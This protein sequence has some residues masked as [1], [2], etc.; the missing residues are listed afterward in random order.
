MASR[1]VGLVKSGRRTEVRS[2]ERKI[3]KVKRKFLMMR[4]VR[5][6][7]G[8]IELIATTVPLRAMFFKHSKGEANPSKLF[9]V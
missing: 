6:A 2:S 3:P 5:E 8:I 9:I 7:S 1:C 4:Q